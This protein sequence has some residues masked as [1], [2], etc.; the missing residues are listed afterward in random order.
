LNGTVVGQRYGQPCNRH[1]ARGPG[2]IHVEASTGICK[3]KW[4]FLF[5]NDRDDDKYDVDNEY[6]DKEDGKGSHG[7]ADDRGETNY[8]GC[9][10]VRGPSFVGVGRRMSIFGHHAAATIFND[11]DVDNDCRRSGEASCPP[12]SYARPHVT[13]KPLNATSFII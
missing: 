2:V 13:G 8:N 10:I 4:E 1:P 3:Y 9:N 7:G 11:N 6:N 12:L 5:H